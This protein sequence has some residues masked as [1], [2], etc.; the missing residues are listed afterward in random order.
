[1]QENVNIIFY[2]GG[3][4]CDGSVSSKDKTRKL[5]ALQAVQ[6]CTQPKNAGIS[7]QILILFYMW[8]EPSVT[9]AQAAKPKAIKEETI[10]VAG[11]NNVFNWCII[12]HYV[13]VLTIN[14]GAIV[15]SIRRPLV[16]G[17]ST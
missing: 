8:A 15:I 12:V 10:F 9:A 2:V 11:Y 16:N 6:S 13:V 14:N 7:E 5:T 4:Q 1:M 17:F 3:T